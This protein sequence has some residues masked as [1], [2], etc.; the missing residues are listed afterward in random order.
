MLLAFISIDDE[1]LA[2][3]DDDQVMNVDE[4]HED[5]SECG[6]PCCAVSDSVCQPLDVG[7][8]NFTY[9]HH[10]QHLNKK[11]TYS[12]SIQTRWYQKYPWINTSYK[13]FCHPCRL[14]RHKDLLHFAKR[15]ASCFIEKGFCNW[16]NALAKLDEHEKCDM[17]KEAIMKLAA[18]DGSVDVSS[19]LSAQLLSDQMFHQSMFFT[20]DGNL[21]KLL[22]SRAEDRPEL[23]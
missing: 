2:C 1:S 3:C 20:L 6:C 16:K 17:H 10:S 15:Q 12:R 4:E 11:K 9:S 23:K 13:I 19:Q 5:V 7:D 14:A 18:Y 21:F 8:S 22:L